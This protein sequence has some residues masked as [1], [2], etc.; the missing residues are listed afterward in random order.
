[1]TKIFVKIDLFSN[2]VTLIEASGAGSIQEV[3]PTKTR[4]EFIEIMGK[5]WDKAV[6]LKKLDINFI[7]ETR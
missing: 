6:K 1:M 2:G 3:I 7:T 5:Y 4:E